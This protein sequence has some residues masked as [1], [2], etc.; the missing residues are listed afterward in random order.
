MKFKNYLFNLNYIFLYLTIIGLN[1][2]FQASFAQG[3]N[4]NEWI[5]GS[6]GEQQASGH[7]ISFGK[8][9]NPVVRPRSGAFG[10]DHSAVAVDPI[11]GNVV[12][13]SDGVLIYDGKNNIM[14][15][16]GS[17]LVDHAGS[18]PVAIG[19]IEYDPEGEKKYY[20][21]YL[22][23]NGELRYAVVD[24]NQ[25]GEATGT[26]PP[27]GAV[28]IPEGNV[29]APNVGE[30]IIV[31]GSSPSFLIS[32]ENGNLV[33]RGLTEEVGDFDPTNT[34]PFPFEPKAFIY[35]EES[36]TLIV[37]PADPNQD[38][39]IVDF[40]PDTGEFGAINPV[41]GSGNGTPVNGVAYSPDGNYLYF[42]RGNQLL[43]VPADDLGATPE[44]V[45]LDNDIEEIFDIK[46]GPDGK[47]Y[48]IYKDPASDALYVGVL[49]NPDEEELLELEVDEDPFNGTDFCG[50][51]FPQFAP[52]ADF[53]RVV[54]FTWEPEMPC[55]NNPIQFTSTITPTN[56]RPVS[57]EWTFSPPLVD[58]DGEE[59]E[60]DYDQ[61]H[62]LMPAE[63]TA[64]QSVTATLT[65]TFADG[66]TRDVTHTINLTENQIQAEFTP[67]DTTVCEGTC[68]DIA[69]LLEAS[70]GDD[71][72][73]GGGVGG[74]GTDNF[75]YFWSDRK[76]QGW[77]PKER[78]CV[79]D[80]PGLYWVLVRDPMNP[81]CTAYASIRINVWDIQD[82]KN[83]IW[84]FG[85]GAGLDF[86]IDPDDPDGPLPRPIERPHPSQIPA[87]VTTISDAGGEVLFYSDGMTV[88][89]ANGVELATEIGGDNQASQSVLAV[90][91]PQDETLY[92]LFTIGNGQAKFTTVDIKGSTEAGF[93]SVP[94]QD[95]FLFSPSTEK[96]AAAGP[97][98]PTWVVF[99]ELGNNTF[100]AYPVTAQGIGQPVFSSV[101]STH[102][103]DSG[104]VGA[105]K[106]NQDG[107][108][109]AVTIRDGGTNRLEIF[110]FDSE[111]GELTEFAL[112]DLGSDGEVYGVEF[113]NDGSRVYVSYTGSNSRVEEFIIEPIDDDCPACFDESSSRAEREECIMSTRAVVTTAGPFGALQIGPDGQVYVARP[114]STIIGQIQ[115]LED[116]SARHFYNA[117]AHAPMPGVSQLGLPAFVN[118]DGSMIPE[119]ALDGPD[120]LCLDPESGVVGLFEG[121]GEPD[122]DTYTWIIR[123]EAGQEV[124]TET[125]GEESQFLEYIFPL[126]GTYNVY[127]TVERCGEVNYFEGDMDVLVVEQ[128]EI[129]LPSDVVLCAGEPVTLTAV[130][131]EDPRFEEY[132]FE[133]R[134]AAGELVG[135]TNEIEVSEESIYTVTVSFRMPE[136]E[137]EETFATCP[138]SKSAFVGP[139]YEFDIDQSEEEV[140]YGELVTFIPDAALEGE[141]FALL[142]GEEERIP[143]GTGY[144]LE[145]ETDV[146]PSAGN[147][148]II[149]V[150]V[151]PINEDCPIEK[152]NS[153]RVNP[154]P[155]FVAESINPDVDCD[156][157]NGVIEITILNDIQSLFIEELELEF[158]A[159]TA[160]QVIT[161]D[162]TLVPSGILPGVYSLLG[163]NG[164]CEYTRTVRVENANPPEEFEF[165]VQEEL[166]CEMEGG[167]LVLTFPAGP[168]SGSYE[169]TREGDGEK[170]T[171][172]F[173]PA[174]FEGNDLLIEN[175]TEGIYAVELFTADGCPVPA[176]EDSYEITFTPV[177]FSI[178]SEASTCG[179][180]VLRPSTSQELIFTVTDE[181]GAEISAEPNGTYLLGDGTFTVRGELADPDGNACPF[182]RTITVTVEE[183]VL[184]D[185]I[186][187]VD[188]C[189]GPLVY[190]ADIGDRTPGDLI[191]RWRNAS[192][193]LV[194]RSQTFTPA[195]AGDYTLEVALQRA[196]ECIGAPI[197]FTVLAL[198]TPVGVELSAPSSCASEGTL[199]TASGNFREGLIFRWFLGSNELPFYDGLTEITAADGGT[200]TVQVYNEA[201][202]FLGEDDIQLFVSDIVP[203]VL[204]DVYTI[205]AIEDF[206]VTIEPGVFD[207]YEWRFEGETVSQ[208]SVYTPTQPG[209]YTLIV[210]DAAG[211][212]A[213]VDFMI[214]EDCLPRIITPTAMRL[215]NPSKNFA[216][217]VNEFVNEVEV[218]IY[219]RWGELIHVDKTLEAEPGKPLLEWDA[220]VRGQD[221]PIGTY[222]VIIRFRSV[223]QN[224]QQ[225]VKRAIIVLD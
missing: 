152:T 68:V 57:F 223:K 3:F 83:N 52:N 20:T 42:S 179:E 206:T 82:P 106:F 122:I 91:V 171:G 157:P 151:D 213:F 54:D 222:P 175:L 38:I 8:G 58:E 117:Q 104:E 193:Q 79:L 215:N 118:M 98:D 45:P 4:N 128:P 65:V 200:Y 139:E 174:D 49:N 138:N 203:P 95:N 111:T 97:G 180:Y 133:W 225:E 89:D 27:L 29:I 198:P 23:P 64:D 28:D 144:E 119:P 166:D 96:M 189:V 190:A 78:P 153:L 167:F 63:A 162:E 19:I 148:Q 127:L 74:G 130:D 114:G 197:D 201:G 208:D 24:M 112:L 137:T 31:V 33:S 109:L 51:A 154:Q 124:Y 161:I 204:E 188:D 67:Q 178:P 84:Y 12:F 129:I 85:D 2:S 209:E 34:F 195:F 159:L 90:A 11:T 145:L 39:Q 71:Q 1:F 18:R 168:Q 14:S 212:E 86:N 21:F 147:Y 150:T 186:E 170:L 196:P 50:T 218:L 185:L 199:I 184:F 108:R 13:Y 9:N 158:T 61:E 60:A 172:T 59:I 220:K 135:D 56:Y 40:D 107:S 165:T 17:G 214:E 62:F 194:S 219:N 16:L 75:E 26:Q 93:G 92:Y 146:L 102:G 183:E 80:K 173:T 76:E 53:D 164:D 143:L 66:T 160:G 15:G 30:A 87:G 36:E 70:M 113:S 202:C 7:I 120:R 181:G 155:E 136:G 140:C 205:C 224:L 207:S 100:R 48:Y 141:W 115:T 142:E 72:Q 110:D 73:Q 177:E 131:P 156:N 126:G 187:P 32:Y 134:N 182:E 149:F 35:D 123:N 47:L 46:V 41:P 192:G 176:Q 217:F 211:C 55:Q 5:F 101:G 125:G 121:G 99:H 77:G 44:A 88:W 132:E 10:S 169:I 221:V 37:I 22:A 69:S 216:V 81:E 210:R 163:N 105:M 43:R 25:P 191:F 116:C 6:C 94:T 103:H